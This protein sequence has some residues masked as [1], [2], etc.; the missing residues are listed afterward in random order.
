MFWT[1]RFDRLLYVGPPDETDREEI[2]RIHLN[3]MKC[4]YI[5]RRDLARQTGGY[6]GADIRLICREAGLAAIEVRYSA[7]ILL[8][9][10]FSVFEYLHQSMI[11]FCHQESLCRKESLDALEIKMQHLETA[12][13]QVKP[14]KTQFYQELSGKFQRLVISNI[15]P[16]NSF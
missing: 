14:T 16:G 3:N 4:S 1:G 15:N 12:I 9:G 2:F 8:K 11:L 10:L 5:N 13:R 7:K 6:T